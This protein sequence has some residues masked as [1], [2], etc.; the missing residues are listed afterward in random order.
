[1]GQKRAIN[2]IDRAFLERMAESNI[3]AVT[4]EEE[5]EIH[6]V[7]MRDKPRSFGHVHGKSP[8]THPSV[9]QFF[10]GSSV[11]SISLF[12]STSSVVPMRP[13]TCLIHPWAERFTVTTPVPH[14]R[15]RL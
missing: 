8:S 10:S 2:V 15:V 13:T 7:I 4:K 6:T 1:M 14:A 3:W 9:G 11:L 12:V 5:E